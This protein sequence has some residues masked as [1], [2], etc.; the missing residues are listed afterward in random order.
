MPNDYFRF[1]RFTIQQGMTA[2][3]VTTDACLFG[4]WI[5]EKFSNLQKQT[6]KADV[7]DLGTGTGLLSLMLAQK[8]R[9]AIDAVEIDAA[10]AIQAKE[11]I[12]ASAWREMVNVIHADAR[13]YSFNKR[14]DLV[15]SNPP[16]YEND[17]H[18]PLTAVNQAR[19]D[20]ALTFHDLLTLVDHLLK[21]DGFFTVLTSFHRY[22]YLLH[23]A[24]TTDLIPVESVLVK[25]TPKHDFTRAMIL[26]KRSPGQPIHQ[27]LKEEL[28]IKEVHHSYSP[29]FIHY[30]EDYY[31][32]L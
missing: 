20:T 22:E 10:A 3:K 4:G 31:L 1:K 6:G 29:A 17:L 30:L 32:S 8:L 25:P 5:A 27:A 19:H 21:Q 11:N 7:L 26:F 16:F 28:I 23:E 24:E 18:S 13:D 14:Y 15:I 9:V 12:E 2:M